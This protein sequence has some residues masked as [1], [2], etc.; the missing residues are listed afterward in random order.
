MGP[1]ASTHGVPIHAHVAGPSAK[2]RRKLVHPGTDHGYLGQPQ[3][4][5]EWEDAA[6]LPLPPVDAKQGARETR[7]FRSC[8]THVFGGFY[9]CVFFA[10]ADMQRTTSACVCVLCVSLVDFPTA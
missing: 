5:P 8:K 10:V 6:P 9:L 4:R 1:G 3:R 7:A 2:A